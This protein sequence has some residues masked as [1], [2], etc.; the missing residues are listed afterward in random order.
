MKKGL[1]YS[2]A[3]VGV[4]AVGFFGSYGTAYSLM[5]VA[6]QENAQRVL[7]AVKSV[8]D[9]SHNIVS[10]DAENACINV[11]EATDTE[12]LCPNNYSPSNMC[13]VEDKL[14]DK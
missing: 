4:M 7:K 6:P 8:C 11:Q 5:S 10:K 13:W 3:A 14:G 12:Y 1:L 9:Y 2:F